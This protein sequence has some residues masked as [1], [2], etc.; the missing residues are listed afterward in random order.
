MSPQQTTNR[1]GGRQRFFLIIGVIL[2]VILVVVLALFLP[3]NIA[4]LSLEP[5]P[6][7]NYA[8]A[9]ERIETL[10]AGESNLNP[11]CRT[12]FMTHG[13]K[14]ERVIIFVH[15]YTNCPQ[16]FTELGKRF[17]AL[18]YNVLIAPEPHHGLADRMTDEQARLT[19]EELAAYSSQVVDIAQGLGDYVVMAGISQ[20]GVIT[21]WAAQNRSDVDLAVLISPGFGFKQIPTPLT[22]AI[23]N[24]FLLAPVSYEWWDPQLMENAG[25]SYAYPR[26][27]RRVL[28]QLIRLGAAVQVEAQQ[29]APAAHAILVVTNAND[30]SVNNEL[31][32]QIVQEW[33]AHGANLSTYEFRTEMGLPHDLI[34]PNQENGNVELVYPSLIELI[35]K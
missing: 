21:A 10:Q 17:Y 1:T 14:T 16:Q 4:G 7:Q 5:H 27:T 32:A 24:F 31:T 28:G 35:N 15:G 9:V 11:V 33:Q 34:D 29:S 25:P 12:Q 23:G 19:A 26:Y 22:T 2:A 3:W 18:G 6:A 8:E 30:T 13:K 20:G